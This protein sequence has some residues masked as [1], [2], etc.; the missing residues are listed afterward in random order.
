MEGLGQ[1]T[2]DLTG[3]IYGYLILIGQFLHTQDGDDILQFLVL[4]QHCL[5]LACSL[6]MLL[7]YHILFQD[8]GSGFQGIHCGVNT[9]FHDLTGQ[10][11]GGIQMCERSRGCGVSQ[12]IR[13][14]VNSL[15]GSDTT[16]VRGSDTFL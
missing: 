13:R 11:G 6:I 14:H 16:L 15:N 3:T 10:N 8:T 4:L 5:H 7:T 1:E 12:V 2:L 9:L